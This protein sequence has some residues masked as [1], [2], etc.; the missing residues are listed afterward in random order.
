[1]QRIRKQGNKDYYIEVSSLEIYCEN[2][3]DLY[4]DNSESN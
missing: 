3:R 2:L 4:A 1:M